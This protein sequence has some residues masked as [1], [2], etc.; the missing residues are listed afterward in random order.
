ML[1]G[2]ITLGILAAVAVLDVLAINWLMHQPYW[3]RE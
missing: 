1:G 2:L 3:F